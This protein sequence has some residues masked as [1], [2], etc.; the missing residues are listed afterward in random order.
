MRASWLRLLTLEAEILHKKC[1]HMSPPPR[2]LAPTPSPPFCPPRPLRPRSAP[3]PPPPLQHDGPTAGMARGTTPGSARVTSSARKDSPCPHSSSPPPPR[4]H[5]RRRRRRSRSRRPASAAASAAAARDP[6]PTAAPR[7]L[8]PRDRWRGG[9]WDVT[10]GGAASRGVTGGGAVSGGMTCGGVAG[11]GVTG[12]GGP[13]QP[14]SKSTVQLKVAQCPCALT[15]RCTGG[16][17]HLRQ[18]RGSGR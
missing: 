13:G 16:G 2:S 10:G 12:G 1:A 8:C 5:P 6:A 4:P 14:A 7:C 18:R 17:G 9:R 11:A 15:V 3:P